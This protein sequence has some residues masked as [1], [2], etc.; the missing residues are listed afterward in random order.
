MKKDLLY[1]KHQA[2]VLGLVSTIQESW[3]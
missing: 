1:I 3:L 2:F